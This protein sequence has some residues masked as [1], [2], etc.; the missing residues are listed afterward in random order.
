MTSYSVM[1]DGN[2]FIFCALTVE[3]LIFILVPKITQCSVE[4]LRNRPS[5]IYC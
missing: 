3:E 1:R 5:L 4:F 2:A